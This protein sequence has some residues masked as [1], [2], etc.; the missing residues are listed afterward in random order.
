LQPIWKRHLEI[1][2]KVLKTIPSKNI[3][4]MFSGIFMGFT[5]KRDID[6]SIDLVP[7]V[8]QVS[9]TPYKI[10]TLKRMRTCPKIQDD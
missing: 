9:K 10:G 6:F 8:N 1:K 3:L 7:V 4:K 2:W 5:P